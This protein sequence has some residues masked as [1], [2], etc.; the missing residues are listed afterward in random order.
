M[1]GYVIGHNIQYRCCSYSCAKSQAESWGKIGSAHKKSGTCSNF[2]LLAIINKAAM[3][4]VE[5]VS[6][7]PVGTSSGY[8]PRRGIVGSSSSTMSNFLRNRQT[9]T[10]TK[11]GAE[12]KGW[13]I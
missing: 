3:N 5:H 11:F 12:T 4:I 1:C 6:F 10:E 2:Q 9:V 7:L 8:M 13:T